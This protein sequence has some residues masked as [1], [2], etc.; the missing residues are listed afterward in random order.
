MSNKKYDDAVRKKALRLH[1][2]EGRTIASVTKVL[3]LGHGTVIVH[4]FLSH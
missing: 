1:L 4:R 2:E 3:H